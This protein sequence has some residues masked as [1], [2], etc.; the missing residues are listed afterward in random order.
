MNDPTSIAIGLLFAATP[1]LAEGEET[2]PSEPLLLDLSVA[3]SD[4][5]GIWDAFASGTTKLNFRYRLES[6]DSDAAATPEEAFASTLRTT[7]SYE[8]GLFH[9]FRG[10]V[11]FED[12]GSLGDDNYNNTINGKTDHPVVADPDGTEVNQAYASYVGCKDLDVKV[13]RQEIILDNARYVGN[14]GWRQNHQSFDAARLTYT[15]V[16]NTTVEYAYIGNVNRIFGEASPVGDFDM[17]SHILNVG[18]DIDGVGK[19]SVYGYVLDFDDA[20]TMSTTTVGARL[21]GKRSVSDS[22][23][24]LYAGEF[25]SQSDTGDNTV[26]VDADYFLAELGASMSGITVRIGSENLSGSGAVGDKFTT[27]LATAHKFN[28]FADLFLTTPDTGLEDF[29]ITIQGTLGKA[30]CR[31]TFHDFS[32]DS[33]NLD[34]GTEI[35]FDAVMP[36]SDRVKAGIK[37]ASFDM[38]DSFA[39]V[40]K[41]MAWIQVAAL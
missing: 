25:A 19:A 40:T 35:D 15:G 21:S 4:S 27:P 38:D 8:T 16:A 12:V 17:S 34:Y 32:S 9:D 7:L 24:V 5:D 11:E 31:A 28:G 26:D 23:E 29:Y 39:D 30:K 22:V 37:I 2:P 14:V 6:V 10:F 41:I 33:G 1:F 20:V 13:G 3:G 36:L 18:H